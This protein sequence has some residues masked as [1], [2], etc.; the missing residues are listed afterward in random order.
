M[1]I[2]QQYTNDD[3]GFF[4]R[5]VKRLPE[6]SDPPGMRYSK[7]GCADHYMRRAYSDI[8][9]VKYD[10]LEPRTDYTV[11]IEG[12]TL[13]D[14]ADIVNVDGYDNIIKGL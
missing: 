2:L 8:A 3:Y 1:I 14:D 11:R 9:I 5:F 4:H 10:D 13:P 7:P 6:L 12:A